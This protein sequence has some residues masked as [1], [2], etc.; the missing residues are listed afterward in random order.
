MSRS[1]WVYLSS[2]SLSLLGNGISSVIFPL[3]VLARTGDVLAAGIVAGVTAAVAAV[4]GLLAGVVIDRV[5]RRTVSI[6]SDLLSAA[7]VAALPVVDLVWGLDMGW[8]VVLAIVGAFGDA[9]GMA[10]R[11]TLLPGVVRLAGGKPGALDRLVGVRESLAAVLMLAGPGLGGLLVWLAGV[12]STVLLITATMSTLAAVLSLGIDRRAGMTNDV[13]DSGDAPA[14]R[15]LRGVALDLAAGWR[16]LAGNR[17]VLGATL[18]TAA[19][20]A[21]V[22]ALQTTLMPA[23]F[24]AEDLAGLTGLVLAGISLGALFGA[25]LYAATV[26]RVTRWAWFVLGMLGTIVGF[27]VIGTM[28]DPWIVLAAAV[29]VGLTNGPV[30]AVLGVATIE[31][32]PDRLRGRVLGAQNA[33]MMGAPAVITA[34]I[35]AAADSWG[36]QTAGVLLALGVAAVAALALFSR[37]FHGLDDLGSVTPAHKESDDAVEH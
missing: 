1:T 12:G 11:E 4:A 30:A 24:L 29:F 28:L 8:F 9:P 26:G 35:A 13:P 2:Y 15:G 36:L 16:F 31:A 23:Y 22:V 37:T 10:A 18:L 21:A 6:A 14:G 17:L 3:L 5:N 32:T 20:T 25:G 33:L 34:P 27:A 7:S 19:L